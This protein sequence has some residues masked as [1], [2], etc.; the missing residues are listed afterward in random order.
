L[1]LIAAQIL[2]KQRS[3]KEASHRVFLA[4]LHFHLFLTFQDF[5]LWPQSIG[6]IKS[7]QQRLSNAAPVLI[8]A[9]IHIKQ[10]CTKEAS[11]RV[12][13]ASLH[14]HIT[15]TFPDFVLWP[16]SVGGIESTQQRLSNAAPV[17]IASQ[18]LIKQRSIKEVLHL[19]KD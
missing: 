18:I 16:Q 12:F 17:L 7:A 11:N 1:V 15:L 6:G 10:R 19:C 5:V 8:A 13:C 4:S 3:T 2:I 9:Q 14:F